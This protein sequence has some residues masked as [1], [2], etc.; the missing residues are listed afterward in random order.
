M[1]KAVYGLFLFQVL[2]VVACLSSDGQVQQESFKE[3]DYLNSP[4][5]TVQ[6]KK[7]Q[8]AKFRGLIMGTSTYDE[9]LR[10]FGPP[11]DSVPSKGE[12]KN[13]PLP[14][15]WHYYDEAGDIPGKLVVG[16]N[17]NSNRIMR[18]IIRP[19]N[20]SLSKEEIIKIYGNDYVVTRYDFDDC[21]EDEESA[22]L[23]ESP[24]GQIKRIEYRERGITISLNYKDIVNEIV[25]VSEPPGSE[26][27]RCKKTKNQIK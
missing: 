20:M 27:S 5:P 17:K 26:K 1:K 21:L 19:Q 3:R 25:Y 14:E 18:I 2:V 15:A 13:D 23:Y 11:K 6:K 7:W 22:P 16:V 24:N 9:M 12:Y 8:P 10:V 4:S